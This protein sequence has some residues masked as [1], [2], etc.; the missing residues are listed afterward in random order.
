MCLQGLVTQEGQV[1]WVTGVCVG[2]LFFD[3]SGWQEGAH[4]KWTKVGFFI[5]ASREA[6]GGRGCWEMR[7]GTRQEKVHGTS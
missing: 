2:G 5:R 6:E 3:L 4:T 7:Q 1:L